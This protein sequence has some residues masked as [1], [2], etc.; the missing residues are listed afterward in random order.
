[1]DKYRE[2]YGFDGDKEDVRSF[3]SQR[4]MFVIRD[5]VLHIAPKGSLDSHAEWFERLGWITPDSDALMNKIT[6]G[7]V[8][9]SGVY[10]YTGFD[11]RIEE[12]VE[13]DLLK[14]LGELTQRLNLASDTK[15]YLGLTP[16]TEANPAWEP[17]KEM[18]TIFVRK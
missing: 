13:E 15:V 1:M 5:G 3:H 6:R 10:A 9:P 8:D 7:Y 17:R 12:F 14:H 11:F 4:I 16:P 2:K 18:G